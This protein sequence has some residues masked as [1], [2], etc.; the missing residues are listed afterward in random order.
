MIAYIIIYT[1]GCLTG[2]IGAFFL[3]RRTNKERDW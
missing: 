1:V 2:L 3:G